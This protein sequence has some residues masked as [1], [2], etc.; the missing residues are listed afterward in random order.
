MTTLEYVKN[1]IPPNLLV[2]EINIFLAYTRY[3]VPFIH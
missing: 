1:T 2:L 3:P